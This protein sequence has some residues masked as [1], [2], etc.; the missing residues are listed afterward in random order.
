MPRDRLSSPIPFAPLG[1]DEPL[2]E[3][4]F[5]GQDISMQTMGSSTTS[6]S[7]TSL[8]NFLQ[9]V[10]ETKSKLVQFRKCISHLS[11][12]HSR[13]LGSNEVQAEQVAPLI[14]SRR[15]EASSL[16]EEVRLRITSMNA[17]NKTDYSAAE[18]EE[19]RQFDIRKSHLQ[20][21][22]RAFQAV[23]AEFNRTEKLARENYRAR[24][25]RQ[26]KVV[27]PDASAEEIEAALNDSQRS[28]QIFGQALL[29]SRQSGARVAYADVQARNGELREIE[30]TII[31][32][33]RMMTDL[34]TLVFEQDDQF[35]DIERN[36]LLVEK[37][38]GAALKQLTVARRLA[39]AARKMR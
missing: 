31:E 25:E 24:A 22:H 1:Q 7:S 18:G 3:G 28:S 27:K 33:A 30:R 5:I 13:H 29:Q 2:M 23:L 37:D 20:T 36:A 32:L 9:Q 38:T 19:R 17:R 35:E 26:Y 34:A 4:K 16:A 39:A 21:L 11:E 6:S 12:L 15:A 10:D 14:L 8:E